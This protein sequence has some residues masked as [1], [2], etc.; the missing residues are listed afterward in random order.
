M[1]KDVLFSRQAKVIIIVIL[2]MAV[3][4][5]AALSIYKH[6]ESINDAIASI[7]YAIKLPFKIAK[8]ASLP[9][10]ESL[11]MPVDGAN[12]RSVADTWGSPRGEGRTH[13]GQDIF[14]PR[15]TIVRSATHGYVTYVG[16]N[17]LGGNVIFILGAGGRRY[18]YAH[19]DSFDPSIGYLTEVTTDTVLGYVG[20]T[21]NAITTPPHLHFGAYTKDGAIDPLPLLTDRDIE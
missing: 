15:G 7:V 20:N 6:R 9:P 11:L 3:A 19:L 21:G 1:K 12:I 14:A 10:D 17:R 5:L 16:Q 8:L 13:E 2:L 18:Y 4:S